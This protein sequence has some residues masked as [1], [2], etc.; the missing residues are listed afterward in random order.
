MVWFLAMKNINI[1]INKE[2]NSLRIEMTN[3]ERIPDWHEGV[4]NKAWLFMDEWIFN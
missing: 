2:V 4:G 3:L 1:K